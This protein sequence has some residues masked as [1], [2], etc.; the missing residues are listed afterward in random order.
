M[1][2]ELVSGWPTTELT[3]LGCLSKGEGSQV[4]K[5]P[6]HR[7]HRDMGD[8]LLVLDVLSYSRK[9]ENLVNNL[10]SWKMV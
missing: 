9:K 3:K 4:H 7:C 1:S 2:L 8:D 5:H 6:F 10:S